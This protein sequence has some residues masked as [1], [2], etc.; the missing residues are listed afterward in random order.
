MSA[1]FAVSTEQEAENAAKGIVQ[2]STRHVNNWA[3]RTFNTARNTEISNDHV[4]DIMI[5]SPQVLGAVWLYMYIIDST[6]RT[7]M[8]ERLQGICYF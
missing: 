7:T 4:P 2:V 6:L 5:F 3:L 8:N 1:R